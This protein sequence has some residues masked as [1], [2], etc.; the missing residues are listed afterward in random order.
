MFLHFKIW[1]LL[2]KKLSKKVCAYFSWNS[3]QSW[4]K[5]LQTFSLLPQ[6]LFTTRETKLDYYYHKVNVQVASRVA[7]RLNPKM[8]GRGQ[9]DPPPSS[10][11]KSLSSKERVK[12]W[13]FVTFNIITSHIFPENVIEILQAVEK[14]WRISLSILAIF[15]DFHQFHGFFYIF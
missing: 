6:F 3:L 7:E 14:L 15:I 4:T 12:P 5:V 11:S 9:T 8:A 1:H 10:F 2:L 13:F